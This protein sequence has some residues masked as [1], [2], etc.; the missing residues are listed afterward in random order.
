MEVFVAIWLVC[1]FVAAIIASNKGANP[2]AGFA[3]GVLLGPIG[4]ALSFFMGT[5]AERAAK[6][7]SSGEKKVCPRCAEAVQPAALVC[8]YCGHE[9]AGPI[10]GAD[11]DQSVAVDDREDPPVLFVLLVI[12]IV[13]AAV[14]YSALPSS[15]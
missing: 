8:R 2:A 15:A 10:G 13:I 3:V 7:V 12:L 6:Q 14:V 1:G 11:M 5:D 4:I 9:F